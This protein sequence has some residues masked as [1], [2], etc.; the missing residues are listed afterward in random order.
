MSNGSTMLPPVTES[1]QIINLNALIDKKLNDAQAHSRLDP[2]AIKI[3]SGFRDAVMSNLRNSNLSPET[4]EKYL[5]LLGTAI[6]Q[7]TRIDTVV[8][9][10]S[11]QTVLNTSEA[12]MTGLERQVLSLNKA[13]NGQDA[14]RIL[15]GIVESDFHRFSEI[16]RDIQNMNYGAFLV[17]GTG[18]KEVGM[19]IDSRAFQFLLKQPEA[20]RREQAERILTEAAEQMPEEQKQTALGDMERLIGLLLQALKTPELLKDLEKTK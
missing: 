10:T 13:Q 3:F 2:D 5:R 1:P 15:N 6:D 20:K 12:V 8:R 18:D 9:N 19:V 4:A 17:A 7:A 14:E 11:D 16:S